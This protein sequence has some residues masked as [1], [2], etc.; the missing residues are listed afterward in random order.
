MVSSDI[1]LK[2]S[3]KIHVPL[4]QSLVLNEKEVPDQ[5]LLKEIHIR[6]YAEVKTKL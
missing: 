5:I 4:H 1:I 2:G 3:T 6:S